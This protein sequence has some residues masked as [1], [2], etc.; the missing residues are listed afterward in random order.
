MDLSCVFFVTKYG[1]VII[2]K[3]YCFDGVLAKTAP[4][5]R[6]RVLNEIDNDGDEEHDTYLADDRR[7]PDDQ[8]YCR[9]VSFSDTTG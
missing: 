2:S 6:L 3:D 7:L 9:V 8:V 4:E 1:D 5:F